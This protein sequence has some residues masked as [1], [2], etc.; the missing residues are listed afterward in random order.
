[1][2][3]DLEQDPATGL[4]DV[5]VYDRQTHRRRRVTLGCRTWEEAGKAARKWVRDRWPERECLMG[6][7]E[8]CLTSRQDQR[9]PWGEGS[10]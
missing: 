8:R 3:I 6:Y 10:K 2:M 7:I 9:R 4:W 5:R 1:M